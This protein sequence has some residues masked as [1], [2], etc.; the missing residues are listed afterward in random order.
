MQKVV[1]V[2]GHEGKPDGN[3][4]PWLKENLE[5]KSCKVYVPEFPTPEDKLD[6]WMHVVKKVPVRNSILVGHSLGVP[7]ILNLLEKEKAKAAFLAAGFTGSLDLEFNNQLQD[8]ADREFDWDAIRQNCPRFFV[9]QGDNDEYV[10]VKK[11]QDLARNLGTDPIL[12][13]GGGHLNEPAG[14]TEFPQLLDLIDSVI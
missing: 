14:F 1:I 8:I 3:W 7:F 2:H 11:A 9:L 5:K 6:K 12:I 13:N 4:F 10:P